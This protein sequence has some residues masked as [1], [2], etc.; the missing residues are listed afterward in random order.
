M[1]AESNVNAE[2]ARSAE[3]APGP[4]ADLSVVREPAW[5]RH[6]IWWRLYPLGFVDAFPEPATGPARADE[7]RLRRIIP[8]L[9]HAIRLGASGIAL[10]PI[11]AS[12]GHGYDTLD[13]LS[14][15]PR[16]GDGADFDLLVAEAHARGLR[17]QL[18]GVF[19][20]VSRNHPWVVEAVQQGPGG[21]AARRLRARGPDGGGDRSEAGEDGTLPFATFEGHD[22]LIALDHTSPQ[23]AQY[24]QH[25][26]RYWLDRGVDAWR[27]DAAYAVPTWFWSEVLPQVRST[28]PSAWFEAE[29]IHGDYC[30]F[31]QQSTADTVTQYELWKAI[32]SSIQDRNFFELDWALRRHNTMLDAFVPSTFVGNHDVTRIASRLTDRRHLAHAVVLLATL[33]GTPTVYAGDEFALQ[34]IKEDRTGGDDAV[35]PAF[36]AEGPDALADADLRMLRLH[37]QLLGLRRRH[38]WLHRALSHAVVLENEQYL[39]R[40]EGGDGQALLV[41]LNLS[42]RPGAAPLPGGVLLGDQLLYGNELLGG[43]QMPVADMLP[44][45]D[46]VPGGDQLTARRPLRLGPHG[47][48][49]LAPDDLLPDD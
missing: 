16:L 41:A 39:L 36:P 28:H 44:A 26:L 34:G 43:G 5:V 14:I 29:V 9:D 3:T 42:D 21:E 19:N 20:H 30:A 12:D 45:T 37:Q 33:G 18:D 25:V 13:H 8:W 15:D 2:A 31:V 11:F 48:A 22:T 1:S 47:W 49:V 35:R 6:A 38:P 46:R 32:W 10:G 7:H 4:A 23:V 17:V 40:L 24:V 27:L